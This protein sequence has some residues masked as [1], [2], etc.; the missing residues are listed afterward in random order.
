M[1]N[2][3]NTLLNNVVVSDNLIT[4]TGGMTPCATIAIGGTCTL[5]GTYTV[6]AAD[7]TAG[8]ITNTGTGDSDET[9]PEDDVLTT[10]VGSALQV[11]VSKSSIPASGTPVAPGDTISYTLTLEVMD[12]PTTADT[13][14]TDTLD[15]DL[16]FG[17]VTSNPGGF[18]IG[19]SG[20][21]LIFT[22]AAGVAVGT[23]EV[24]Y[25][26]TINPDASGD[27]GNVVVITGGTDS[28]CY[29]CATG[30]PLAGTLTTEIPTASTLGLFMLITLL[31]GAA[32]RRLRNR[33]LDP[34]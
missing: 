11:V 17:S 6:T 32:I 5:I 14:L 15:A 20:N 9:P 22:L 30:H 1:T 31:A 4:P 27:V 16:T 33:G 7:A 28:D 21:V 24:E 10:P 19:G 8:S 23:Y 2:T 13:E 25:T 12:G 18:A 29:P 3:G 26:A 34:I